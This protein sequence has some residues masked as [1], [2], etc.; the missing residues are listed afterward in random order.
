[1][2]ILDTLKS[3][4][5]SVKKLW[6]DLIG[7]TPSQSAT[8]PTT[9]TTTTPTTPEPSTTNII[10]NVWTTLPNVQTAE[11]LNQLIN[12]ENTTPQVQE[13]EQQQIV[14][15]PSEYFDYDKLNQDNVKKALEER[16]SWSESIWE[17]LTSWLKSLGTTI[18]QYDNW[19]K[20]SNEYERNR[21]ATY[22]WYNRD[23]DEVYQLELWKD[24]YSDN[25]KTITTQQA[26]ENALSKYE[27][28][29]DAYWWEDAPIEVKA[30][31]F[32]Q[33]YEDTKWM[34]VAQWKD[35]YSS[36]D[37][38]KRRK[39]LF[40]DEQLNLLANNWVSWWKRE[41]SKNQFTT[42][43][44]NLWKNYDLQT[45]L[46]TKY[47]L[48]DEDA[49]DL[50][51]SQRWRAQEVFMNKVMNW[52][53]DEAKGKLKWTAL[54]QFIGNAYEAWLNDFER[55]WENASFTYEDAAIL[56]EKIKQGKTL[57]AEEAKVLEYANTFDDMFNKL[58][59]SRNEFIL[60]HLSNDSVW[61]DWKIYEA[62]DIFSNW[63]NLWNVMSEPVLEAAWLELDQNKSWIDAFQRIGNDAKLAYNKNVWTRYWDIWEQVQHYWW[64]VW[65]F[66][67]EGWQTTVRW[68]AQLWNY[69]WDLETLNI[70][71]FEDRLS[72]KKAGSKIWEYLNQDAT[73]WNLINTEEQWMIAN[74]FWQDAA[75][76]IRK[77]TRYWW[78][79][80]PEFAWN[81]IPDILLSSATWWGSVARHIPTAVGLVQKWAK[82]LWLVNAANKIKWANLVRKAFGW[83]KW[84][85]EWAN[86][87]IKAPETPSYLKYAW[88]RFG[89]LVKDW[90][91]D[92]LID[93]Q[94]SI[95]DTEAYS[96]TSFG[97]SIWW[98]A[99]TEIVPWL[100][101]T[102]ILSALANS[103]MWNYIT[104]GTAWDAIE[105]LS[106]PENQTILENSIKRFW[107]NWALS[108][109][110]YR[111]I[112]DNMSDLSD[113]LKNEYNKLP[114]ELKP[115]ATKWSKDLAWRLMN[116]VYDVNTN[117]ILWRNL[118]AIISKEWTN[119][120]DLFK[121]IGWI[122]WDVEIGPWRS[123][124]KLK[125]ADG[126]VRN[127]LWIEWGSVTWYNQKLDMVLDW[128]LTKRLEEWFTINDINAI[129]SLS[130]YK[131]VTTDFFSIWDDWKYYLTDAWAKR[132]WINTIDMPLAWQA[133]KIA[134]AEAWE[135]SERFQDVMK[136]VRTSRRNLTDDTI[137]R[138]ANS[139]TYQDVRDKVA[140]IVC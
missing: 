60:E 115:A 134:Q 10:W 132:L 46:Q 57:T 89:K 26:F 123:I 124:I 76:N 54:Q 95:Y 94:Y 59:Y 105:F 129:N 42:F 21:L 87:L 75:R 110:D 126:S 136:N 66:L 117:S 62:R 102:W 23:S 137:D 98:T 7:N 72:W 100:Y 39:N 4:W 106:K 49:L 13:E 118:R 52:I 53:V 18:R 64:Y 15:N 74:V 120:A 112:A 27:A 12:S 67:W 6:N 93:A 92:Q 103:A 29:L 3:W 77:F 28:V 69:L 80:W 140:D 65:D 85:E 20:L 131:D 83:I 30:Q 45:S 88:E 35:W 90:L 9:T 111:K 86:A 8:T 71:S 122:P 14:S 50:D 113:F 51:N 17:W 68:L 138:I 116:Q 38:L 114:N 31:A 119:L 47:N 70:D 44:N 139:W 133:N 48:T 78:E 22:I 81:I 1:M 99:L 109:D 96:D 97:F 73:I 101:K 34:F 108:F 91:I 58:A 41:P 33:L 82:A 104:K 37:W 55:A 56:R 135:V 24:Y 16:E 32:E 61:K 121:Y 79:Y 127:M 84:L 36:W 107:K 2:A 25:W 128:W 125:N 19:G 11:T 43:I 40:T 63:R 130:D 5:N